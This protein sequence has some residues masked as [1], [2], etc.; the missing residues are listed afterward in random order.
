MLLLRRVAISSRSEQEFDRMQINRRRAP[1]D[2]NEYSFLFSG[3]AVTKL[4]SPQLKQ[5]PT[6]HASC[7]KRCRVDAAMAVAPAGASRHIL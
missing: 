3:S 4:S 5:E 6:G 7:L 2:A 1:A